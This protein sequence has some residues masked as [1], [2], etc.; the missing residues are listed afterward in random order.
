MV[1]GYNKYQNAF[2]AP[3]GEVLSCERE[4]GNIHDTFALVIKKDGK[5]FHHCRLSLFQQLSF[6]FR[7]SELVINLRMDPYYE[8]QQ[9]EVLNLVVCLYACI[10]R[11]KISDWDFQTQLSI[12][13]G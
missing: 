1:N 10:G 13:I 9:T 5:G 7:T 6:Q 3:I 11:G 12:R 4:V 2:D 8:C